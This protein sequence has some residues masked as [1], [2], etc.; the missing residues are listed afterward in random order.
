VPSQLSSSPVSSALRKCRSARREHLCGDTLATGPVTT[1][2]EGP[3]F[4]ISVS[5]DHRYFLD[6]YAQPI[7][8]K[9]DSPWAMMTDVSPG[10]A[11]R[12]FS[13]RERQGFNAAIISLLGNPDNGGPHED[14]ST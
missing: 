13:T 2:H 6:Q 4:V 8:I 5:P 11:E 12:W 10:Q 9:G 14:G 1:G 7:L 3:P